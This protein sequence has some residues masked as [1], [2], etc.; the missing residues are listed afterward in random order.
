[1]GSAC[2]SLW[3]SLPRCKKF[4]RQQPRSQCH[5]T[6]LGPAI[7]YRASIAWVRKVSPFSVLLKIAE[8]VPILQNSYLLIGNSK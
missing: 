6:V 4:Q 3:L 2:Q 1:M 7:S 5:I 8:F